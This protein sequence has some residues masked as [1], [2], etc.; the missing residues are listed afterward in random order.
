M[1]VGKRNPRVYLEGGYVH[2]Y[3][4]SLSA[5]RSPRHPLTGFVPGPGSLHEACGSRR[6][7]VAACQCEGA[8]LLVS[9][10]SISSLIFGKACKYTR[11]PRRVEGTLDF[12]GQPAGCVPVTDSP[13]C[14]IHASSSAMR[15]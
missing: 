5:D 6:K 14:F 1:L 10:R 4:S 9:R 8:G 3:P 7:T 13:L 12:S 15:R 2:S 11:P